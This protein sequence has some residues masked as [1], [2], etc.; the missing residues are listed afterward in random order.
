MRNT[1]RSLAILIVAGTL[2]VVA[3]PAQAQWAAKPSVALGLAVPG[4]ALHDAVAEGATAKVG[5][6]MRAPRV[7]V[8]FTAEAMYTH[9]R[10]GRTVPRS[11]N[12]RIASVL[13]NVTTRRHEG[14]LDPYGTLGVGWYWYTDPDRR[15]E[16]AAAP[17]VDVGIG[18]VIAL[19]E[20]D[21]FVEVRL[22]AVRTPTP[23]GSTWTTFLPLM[24]GIRF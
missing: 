14:R 20:R 7:P 12:M 22:H 18:E 23:T 9:L 10:G 16:G 15:F 8:G 5:L 24:L 17:G 6:W 1:P 21:Y 13:A 11:D 19:A 3:K 4:G 2:S